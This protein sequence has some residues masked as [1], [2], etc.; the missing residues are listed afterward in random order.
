M[1]PTRM[2]TLSCESTVGWYAINMLDGRVSD[3]MENGLHTVAIE[4]AFLLTSN[5]Q[6]FGFAI[7]GFF[8]GWFAETMFFFAVLPGADAAERR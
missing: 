7:A 6:N 2:I 5:L 4:Y 3:M 8:H 1:V